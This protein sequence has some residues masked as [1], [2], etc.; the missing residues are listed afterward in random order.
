MNSGADR[1]LYEYCTLRFVPDIERGEFVNVGLL[2]MCKRRRWLRAALRIDRDRIRALAPLAD[3]DV[4]ASQLALFTRDDVPAA[5][6]PV[7]ERFRWLAAVKSAVI[8]TSPTHPGILKVCEGSTA[9]DLLD[10]CF[11]RLF[12]RLV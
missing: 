8:Q 2:M 11:E 9:A 5:D 6:L 10:E 3:M 4:L 7:E 12:A 1:I